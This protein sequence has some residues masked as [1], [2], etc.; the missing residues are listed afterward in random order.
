MKTGF[1]TTCS[2]NKVGLGLPY[3][4]YSNFDKVQDNL[5]R[6]RNNLFESLKKS[7][8]QKLRGAVQGPDFTMDSR[9][10]GAYLPAYIRYARGQFMTSLDAQRQKALRLWF[11]KN[12]LFF[13]SGLYGIVNAFEPIQNYDVE[14]IGI[15]ED[16]WLKNREILTGYLIGSLDEGSVLLDCCGVIKYSNIINWEEVEKQG[17]LVFHAVSPKYEG[18]QVRAEAG[19]LAA[20]ITGATLQRI[21]NG[22]EFPGINAEIKFINNADFRRTPLG[23]VGHLPRI[24]VIDTG[25]DE[26]SEIQKEVKRQGWSRHFNFERIST[27]ESLRRAYSGGIKQCL[28]LIPARGH[29]YLVQWAGGSEINALYGGDLIKFNRIS[30]LCLKLA[31]RS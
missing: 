10:T 26:F 17:F 16:Y 21:K 12:R 9:K 30:E 29:Q 27:P 3:E 1:L 18:G 11:K 2:K 24:G 28:C 5:L 25:L 22:A 13:V 4:E 6:A 19:S 7:D 8:P 31:M 14:L 20:N 23:A 15:A